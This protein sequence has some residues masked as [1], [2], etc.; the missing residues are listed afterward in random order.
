MKNIMMILQHPNTYIALTYKIDNTVVITVTPVS[1]NESL[2]N[3]FLDITDHVIHSTGI[4]HLS[5]Y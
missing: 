3:F 1:F 5:I 4:I 2:C